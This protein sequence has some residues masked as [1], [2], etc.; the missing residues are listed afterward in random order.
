MSSVVY[1][2]DLDTRGVARI[3]IDPPYALFGQLLSSIIAPGRIHRLREALAEYESSSHTHFYYEHDYHELSLDHEAEMI[4][5]FIDHP[6]GT[7]SCVMPVGEFLKVVVE[8][9]SS[10]EAHPLPRPPKSK[11]PPTPPTGHPPQS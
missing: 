11:E 7:L 5:A 3:S 4:Q 6:D 2:I 8:W 1:R 9:L 10:A